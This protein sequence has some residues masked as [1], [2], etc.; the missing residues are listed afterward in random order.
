MNLFRDLLIRTIIIV[1]LTDIVEFYVIQ[2]R[3]LK[4]TPMLV[5]GVIIVTLV[6][7]IISIWY[8]LHRSGII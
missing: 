3:H 6:P 1:T 2:T 7:L 4:I 8:S 5:F